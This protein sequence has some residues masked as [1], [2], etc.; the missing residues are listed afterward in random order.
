MGRVVEGQAGS[1][2][3]MWA[4]T[5]VVRR[6]R[7]PRPS[8]LLLSEP[9]PLQ[10]TG[11]CRAGPPSSTSPSRFPLVSLSS[12]PRAGLG[13]L[14]R[15]LFPSVPRAD[16]RQQTMGSDPKGAARRH[17]RVWGSSGDPQGLRAGRA[18]AG[19]AHKPSHDRSL[20]PQVVSR[21]LPRPLAPLAN[22]WPRQPHSSAANSSRR[23]ISENTSWPSR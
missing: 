2:G 11:R 17:K 8:H 14:D 6:P 19:G 4:V 12:P 15:V 13:P 22:K 5:R 10:Q 7:P 9:V 3:R 1:P 20:P 16:S 23:K 18:C 21:P